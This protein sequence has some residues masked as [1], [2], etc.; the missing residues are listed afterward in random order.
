MVVMVVQAADRDHSTCG[1][2]KSEGDLFL[3]GAQPCPSDGDSGECIFK[4][5]DHYPKW[6]MEPASPALKEILQ[7]CTG[8][9]DVPRPLDNMSVVGGIAT[10]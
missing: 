7:L 10:I 3:N 8:W 1:F 4:A 6:T 9:Q 2:I 5:Q